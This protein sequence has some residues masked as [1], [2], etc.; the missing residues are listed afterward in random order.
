MP[1][2]NTQVTI[3]QDTRELIAS[4]DNMP[5]QVIVHDDD[6]GGSKEVFLGNE[7]VTDTNGL[8]LANGDTLQM[9]LRPGDKLYAYAGTGS[10]VVHVLQIQNN[11]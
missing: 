6:H 3:A 11:D 9:M 7:T 1:I 4:A 10:C 8:H 5:Q 2:L